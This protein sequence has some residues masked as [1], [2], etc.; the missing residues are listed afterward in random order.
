VE[1]SEE[2]KE[3]AFR[4]W[5]HDPDMDPDD[6]QDE[7]FG[8]LNDLV[9]D[10][11]Y[12]GKFIIAFRTHLPAVQMN[13]EMTYDHEQWLG[14]NDKEIDV[15][16]RVLLFEERWKTLRDKVLGSDSDEMIERDRNLYCIMDVVEITVCGDWVP[17]V[18]CLLWLEYDNAELPQLIA[19]NLQEVWQRT[20]LQPVVPAA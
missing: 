20:L 12:T 7:V 18:D 10:S 11:G 17:I 8:Y 1:R 6:M 5:D 14:T 3:I 9:A 4:Y 16:Q 19:E 2:S 15:E 13:S